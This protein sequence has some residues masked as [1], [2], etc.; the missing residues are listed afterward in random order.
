M[1][2][3]HYGNTFQSTDKKRGSGFLVAIKIADAT[4]TDRYLDWFGIGALSPR[5]IF[6]V[7][8]NSN[9]N[10]ISSQANAGIV[11]PAKILLVSCCMYRSTVLLL[12]LLLL[13]E[14]SGGYMSMHCTTN[15]LN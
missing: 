6:L 1:V 11:V 2:N 10:N 3:Y 8:F 13:M 4:I 9:D 14:R 15:I 5:P 7:P 12:L